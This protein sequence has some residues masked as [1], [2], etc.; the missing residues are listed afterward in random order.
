VNECMWVGAFI[1]VECEFALLLNDLGFPAEQSA[2]DD[3]CQGSRMDTNTLCSTSEYGATAGTGGNPSLVGDCR[4]LRDR[5]PPLL[6]D[7]VLDLL[8]RSLNVPIFRV[9]NE[10]R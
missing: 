8:C 9:G 4:S 7:G 5:L 6:V 1:D 10:R 3:C 2:G